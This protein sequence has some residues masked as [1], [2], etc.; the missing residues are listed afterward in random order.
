MSDKHLT[1]QDLAE[2]WN[3]TRQVVYGMRHR[4]EGPPAMRIG[5]ELRWRLEDV[6]LWE[7]TR[8]EGDAV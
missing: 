4:R 7:A 8:R 5:R 3:T 6:E 1:I 2:R